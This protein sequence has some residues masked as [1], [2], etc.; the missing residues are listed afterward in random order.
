MGRKQ[1]SD[2]AQEVMENLFWDLDNLEVYIDNIGSFSSSFTNH[3]YTLDI[4]I[5]HLEQTV[6]P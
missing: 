4:I 3:V 5:T 6:L 1:Y 2:I